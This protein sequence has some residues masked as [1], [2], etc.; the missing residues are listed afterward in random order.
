MKTSKE[1][2]RDERERQGLN[3]QNKQCHTNK[4]M[5]QRGKS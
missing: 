3:K 4:K 5:I 2:T 1:K